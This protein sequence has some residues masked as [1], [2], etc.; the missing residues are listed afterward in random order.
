M[1]FLGLVRDLC[2]TILVKLRIGSKSLEEAK[3][4]PAESPVAQ[5]SITRHDLIL[6]NT[7]KFLVILKKNF[8]IP[9][10][11]D[12]VQASLCIRA[13]VAGD[14]VTCGGNGIFQVF[15]HD[16]HLTAIQLSH[17]CVHDMY[18]YLLF[19]IPRTDALLV[20]AVSKRGGI[21][22]QFLPFPALRCLRSNNTGYAQQA[23]AL[24]TRCNVILEF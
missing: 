4:N 22:A 15:S 10:N 5:Q 2:F 19:G 14:P 21:I 9:S 3:G 12:D 17:M 6:I 8:D 11:A 13:P 1:C 7:E 24:N 23:V 20:R 16:N 18:I